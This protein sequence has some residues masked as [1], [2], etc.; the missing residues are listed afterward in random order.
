MADRIAPLV[1]TDS[2][3]SPAQQETAEMSFFAG[4]GERKAVAKK[5]A[6][7]TPVEINETFGLSAVDIRNQAYVKRFAHIAVTYM[8]TYGVPASISLAQGLLE[9]AGGTSKM[10]VRSNNHFGMKCFSRNCRKGHCSNYPDDT[11]KDFFLN[12]KAAW[13]SWRAHS[14]LVTTKH[15]KSLPKKCKKNYREWAFG[16]KRLGYATDPNYAY[17]LIRLIERHKLNVYDTQ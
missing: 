9:S 3:T 2:V 13:E 7:D 4:E 8:H 12:Y 6:K 10:A 1:A 11:H 17:A 5:V 14:I 15:Y 16:L